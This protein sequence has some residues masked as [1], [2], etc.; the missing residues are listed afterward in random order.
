M[1]SF[2][3]PGFRGKA[4]DFQDA[5]RFHSGPWPLGAGSGD[6]GLNPGASKLSSVLSV[7]LDQLRSKL[8]QN[9]SILPGCDSGEKL[10]ILHTEY[11]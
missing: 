9:I 8:S 2:V 10:G 1:M 5:Q 4:G 3:I 11:F 6:C 7:V